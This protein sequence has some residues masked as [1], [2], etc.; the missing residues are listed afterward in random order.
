MMNGD[1]PESKAAA[2]SRKAFAAP[3]YLAFR[4]RSSLT[5]S[6]PVL[7]QGGKSMSV[8]PSGVMRWP[9]RTRWAAQVS[10]PPK[11]GS[12]SR[13]PGLTRPSSMASTS[14]TAMV[15][16]RH[17]AVPVDV[18]EHLVRVARRGACPPRR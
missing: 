14:A 17:V 15:A 7:S 18:D 16:A 10:P 8:L 1:Q 2:S 11:P 12:S 5:S 9:K 6:R 13:A 4:A 3:W